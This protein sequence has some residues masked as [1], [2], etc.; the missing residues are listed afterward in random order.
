[1]SVTQGKIEW[2]RQREQE[3][4]CQSKKAVLTEWRERW[5]KEQGRKASWPE[6][7]AAL[8]QPS[9]SCL[10]LY[11]QLKKAES[12]ALFQARTGRIGLR[13]FLASVR[14]PGVESDEC[15]CEGGKETAEHVLL[16]CANTPQRVW[17]RGAQ[18]QKLASEPAAVGQIARQLIQCGRLG[19][20]R[21]ASRLLYSG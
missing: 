18:F 14:V 3:Y 21:L 4:S 13:R 10:K 11:S 12:S 16:H 20:F 1:V 7:I 2:A 6:S 5:H 19:Q 15:L 17:S 8:D 9:Q